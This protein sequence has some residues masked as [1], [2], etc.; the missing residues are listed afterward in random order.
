MEPKLP[1]LD[2]PPGPSTA[3]GRGGCD[4]GSVVRSE[5]AL[6]VSVTGAARSEALCRGQCRADVHCRAWSWGRADGAAADACYLK[7]NCTG[8]GAAGPHSAPAH[9]EVDMATSGIAVAASSAATAFGAPAADIATD[10]MADAITP[11]QIFTTKSPYTSSRTTTGIS[12]V[13]GSTTLT[14]TA[15]TTTYTNTKTATTTTYTSTKSTIAT[16]HV[17]HPRGSLYCFALMIPGSYEQ[18]LLAMQ[19]SGK[20]S[21]FGCEEYGVYSSQ[22]IE[23]AP[24]VVASVVQSDLKCAYGGEF[25]TAL[26]TEIFMAVWD[27]VESE[28]RF[29]LCDWTVKTDPDTVFFPDRLRGI[30]RALHEEPNGVYLNN[31]KFGFHGPLEVFSRNAVTQW[32]R[33]KERCAVHFTKLCSGPCLWGEDMFIDQCLDKVLG[34]ERAEEWDLLVEAHCAPPLDWAECRDGAKVSFHPFKTV[35]G[36][37][38]CLETSSRLR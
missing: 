14:A 11:T 32:A 13:G 29:R 30:V 4:P 10:I 28:G 17:E 5:G 33:G 15:T 9:A 36:Y 3:T 19:H 34:V 18:G 25:K 23:V 6:Q 16:T 38:A 27:K 35:E 7:L 37:R 22:A 2:P 24:G 12:A 8:A 20:V 31:C 1:S 21:I 26:N